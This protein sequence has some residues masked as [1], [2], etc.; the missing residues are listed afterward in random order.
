MRRFRTGLRPLAGMLMI[1]LACALAP[2]SAHAQEV[3]TL[4]LQ[5]AIDL[6]LRHSP[7]MAQAEGS[8]TNALGAERTAIGAFLPSLSM[9]SG[10]SHSSSERF[11]PQTNTSVT[12]SS[13][14]YNAGIS[15][16][17]ELFTGGR[18]V[19]ELSRARAETSASEA[20]L[21]ESR[22]AVIL[23]AKRAFF[24]VLRAD[25]LIRVAEARLQRAQED[26]EAAQRRQQVGSATRSDVLRAQL[27]VTNARQTLLQARNQK[28]TAAFNL[29]RLVGVTGEVEARRDEADFAVEP[30]PMGRDELARLVLEAAPRVRSAEAA[31]ESAEAGVKAARAQYLPSIRAS[32]GYNWFN[33]EAVLSTG[34]TSW[35][36]GLSLSYPIFNGFNREVAVERSRVQA[37]VAEIQREDARRAALAELERV[38]GALTLAEEQLALTEE[39][40]RVAEEDLR[41]Q[42]ERYRLG[43][44]TILDQVASQHNLVQAEVNRITALYD[45][46]LARAELEALI[47]RDL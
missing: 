6:A 45:Y 47:G 8:V 9:S 40:V 4:T 41:V 1:P 33:Q 20:A 46:L 21:I 34:R 7:Q 12:G 16:S 23:S 43:V 30:L 27:E 39:A 29:G 24:E 36:L 32:S 37:K 42:Q 13:N 35:S 44:S 14:S 19:A 2:R 22:F 38:L 26:L 3:P 10:A 5:E 15:A 11:N 28:R 31:L 17:L 25:D 18:R